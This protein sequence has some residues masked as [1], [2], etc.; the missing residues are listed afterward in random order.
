MKTLDGVAD[1]DVD[2]DR[3]LVSVAD[4]DEVTPALVNTLASSGAR[5][6]RVAEVEHTLEK[7]YLDLVDRQ[8][9][10]EQEDLELVTEATA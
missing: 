8:N 10:T 3:L 4:P 9:L 5:I 7:A 1:V 2:E 6:L